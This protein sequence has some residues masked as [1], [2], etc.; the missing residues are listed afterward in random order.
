LNHRHKE[1]HMTTI[2]VQKPAFV[3]VPRAAPVAAEVFFAITQFVERVL[4]SH[5]ERRAEAG[6]VAEAG[7]VRRYAE[8]VRA[9]DPRFAAD[10][11]AAADRHELG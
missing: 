6:R 10:L 3:R 5:S 1:N 8:S 4:T 11:F 7:E 9:A 2:T